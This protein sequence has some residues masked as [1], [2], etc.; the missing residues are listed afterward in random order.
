VTTGAVTSSAAT[1]V[2]IT[3]S[4]KVTT[5]LAAVVAPT[6]TVAGS[7]AVTLGT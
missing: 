4:G 5:D 2:A 1:T 6:I 7:G 3:G